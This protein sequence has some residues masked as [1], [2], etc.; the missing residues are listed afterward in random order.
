MLNE[1]G[2]ELDYSIQQEFVNL[3][4]GSLTSI[5]INNAVGSI[6]KSLPDTIY[7]LTASA[8]GAWK[9]TDSNQPFTSEM[10]DAL[11]AGQLYLS[12]NTSAQAEEITGSIV[13]DT[14]PWYLKRGNT[15]IKSYQHN[16]GLDT[17]VLS[18]DG[19]QLKLGNFNFNLPTTYVSATQ[20]QHGDP[21][22]NLQLGF[23]GDGTLFGFATGRASDFYGYGGNQATIN[24]LMQDIE[25]R[26]TGI[27]VKTG[28]YDTTIVSGGQ[29]ATI[30]SRSNSALY[31]IRIPF[32]V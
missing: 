19:F 16:Y 14:Y 5:T 4:D 3:L 18:I 20:M 9:L 22:D 8:K 30:R 27:P 2:D 29:F 31:K 12:F 26:F 25:F 1:A 7:L 17:A 28:V 13:I 15:V 10:R 6:V 32:E 24:D 11:I 21:S 23:W